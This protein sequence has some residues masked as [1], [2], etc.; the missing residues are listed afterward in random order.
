GT[1]YPNSDPFLVIGAE[2]HDAGPTYPSYSGFLDE[3]RLSDIAR[4]TGPFTPPNGPFTTDGNTVALFHFDEGRGD[5]INDSSGASGG[6]SDGQRH[7]GGHPDNGPEW[8]TSDLF[9]LSPRLF[10]PVIVR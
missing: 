7:Y 5:S 10:L 2:K 4:Y 6:P 8:F 9:F 1:S 3:I